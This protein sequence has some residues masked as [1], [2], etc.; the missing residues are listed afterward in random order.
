VLADVPPPDAFTVTVRV[1]RVA[2]LD[3]VIFIVVLP[4]ADNELGENVT[5]T[6]LA[7]PD[8]ENVTAPVV[9]PASVIVTFPE[10]PREIVI[11]LGFAEIVYFDCVVLLTVSDTV[12][13]CDRLPLVPVIVIEYVPAA[14]PEATVNVAVEL[15]EP[16][17]DVG[18]NATVTP[19]GMPLA[20][21]ETAEANPSTAPIVT[22]DV[23]FAPGATVSEPGFAEI[24]KSGFCCVPEPASVVTSA[25]VGLPH[26]VTRS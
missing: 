4:A 14:V 20:E 18:L 7:S 8:A 12:V 10:Y 3:T 11:A 2:L 15:P 26:P 19:L 23:P 16:L 25:G 21:S 1:V 22:V 9:V 24:V 13:E 5:V 17:T 6:P